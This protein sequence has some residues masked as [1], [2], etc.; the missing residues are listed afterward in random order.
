MSTATD[1]ALCNTPHDHISRVKTWKNIKACEFVAEKG[2]TGD[3]HICRPCRDDVGRVL[4][5]STYH[6][7]W[8]K[9]RIN[10]E[11]CIRCCT[12]DVFASSNMAD[13]NRMSLAVEECGLKS[14]LSVL[15]I[16]T[17]LCKHHYHQLY[18]NI[19][20]QPNTNCPTCN[21]SLKNMKSRLS[22]NPA[23]I[24]QHLLTTT[25]FDGHISD[26]DRVCF[27]CYK[28]QLTIIKGDNKASLDSELQSLLE[29]VR[30]RIHTIS[31]TSLQQVTN[32]AMDKTILY[33]G[34]E[35]LHRKA[36]LLPTVH[37]LFQKYCSELLV[38]SGLVGESIHMTAMWVFC[39]L[40]SELEHH[41]KYFCSIRKYGTLLY[42]QTSDLAPMLQQTLWKLGQS[43]PA[44]V[45]DPENPVISSANES[46]SEVLDHLNDL[47]HDQCQKFIAKSLYFLSKYEKLDIHSIID[48]LNP[49]LWKAICALT[50][51]T[52]DRIGTSKNES[53]TKTV[54]NF[55]LLCAILFSTDDR[56][57]LPMH[58][59]ITDVVESHGG[60]AHLIKILNRLGLC[61][62]KDTLSR[63]R[64]TKIENLGLP[65][66]DQFSSSSFII[67]SAD[68]IDFLHKFSQICNNHKS[69]WHGTTVQLVQPLPGLELLPAQSH[70]QLQLAA[71][72]S[73]IPTLELRPTAASPAP[74]TPTLSPTS[75]MPTLE[76]QPMATS[77]M[78]VTPTL[79]LQPM[80]TSPMSVTPTLQL[81]PMANSPTSVTPTLQL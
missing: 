27:T 67:V 15:P 74:V 42:R 47:V 24:E 8:E 18:K 19:Q 40:L 77:P 11:C 25:G 64:Q 58:T 41:L 78:S 44:P 4:T 62:S 75:V 81:Q 14:K 50:R 23:I 48:Q 39:N 66:T 76:L 28:S 21:T 5:N 29:K 79:Q 33:V 6:P 10:N 54:R 31:P 35:L 3:N 13:A 26:T 37:Q 65:C 57:S 7:R 60:S 43:K 61:A 36:M 70:T 49:E 22:P 59:L 20:V 53:N 63:F 12:N 46:S 71:N 38:K 52:R 56:C 2:I 55:F 32:L 34:Q 1:C 9:Q 80:A 16:P 17:P 69:S 51:S 73:V 45:E 30:Y 72:P 68:N